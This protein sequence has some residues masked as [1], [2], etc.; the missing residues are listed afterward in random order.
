MTI[1]LKA[2]KLLSDQG[3]LVGYHDYW[4][5]RGTAVAKSAGVTMNFNVA[6]ALIIH[7][8][9]TNTFGTNNANL[10]TMNQYLAIQ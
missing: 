5:A 6:K 7:N 1:D 9:G 4:T 3:L 10:V 2:Q 8:G